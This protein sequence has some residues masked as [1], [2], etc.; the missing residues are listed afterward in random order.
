MAATIYN[1][2]AVAFYEKSIELKA[3]LLG[4]KAETN[5]KTKSGFW[6]RQDDGNGSTVINARVARKGGVLLDG[7]RVIRFDDKDEVYERIEAKS[8]IHRG[9]TWLLID[10]NITDKDQKV[11]QKRKLRSTDKSV[12]RIPAGIKR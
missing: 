2:V 11:A 4:G 7:V 9:D 3:E 5:A 1:P 6:L 10:A 12:N 8:A